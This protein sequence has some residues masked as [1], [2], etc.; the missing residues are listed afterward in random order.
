[1]HDINNN[2]NTILTYDDVD[3]YGNKY[4]A[5]FVY[6]K[7]TSIINGKAETD[8]KCKRNEGNS[9]RDYGSQIRLQEDDRQ[10]IVAFYNCQQKNLEMSLTIRSKIL[11][12]LIFSF[13]NIYNCTCTPKEQPINIEYKSKFTWLSI[14]RKLMLNVELRKTSV[15][16]SLLWFST[17]I[18]WSSYSLSAL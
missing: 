15:K 2:L 17:L 6:T 11:K 4:R 1:M 7:A 16:L 14:K 3:S 9:H 8:M 13:H 12:P 18:N 5:I 10:E